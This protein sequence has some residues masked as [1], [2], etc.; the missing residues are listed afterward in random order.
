MKVGL[1]KEF[2]IALLNSIYQLNDPCI[3]YLSDHIHFQK[4]KRDEFLLVPGQ[5]SNRLYFIQKGLLRAYKLNTD[6]E[7]SVWFMK[8]KD[9]CTS[10]PSFYRQIASIEYIQAL[11]DSEL[12]YIT[13]E[14]Y[15]HLCE[16]YMEFNFVAR[17]L[18]TQYFLLWDELFDG[19]RMR[20]AME[21]YEWLLA[22]HPELLLR[23]PQKYLASYFDMTEVSFSKMKNKLIEK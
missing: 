19:I 17:E 7:V 5:V 6:T 22:N 20:S 13:F 1:A 8:E 23:V 15:K 9:F 4:A 12:L 16:H 11:E 14:D 2:A 10:V 21:R 3:K 18:I